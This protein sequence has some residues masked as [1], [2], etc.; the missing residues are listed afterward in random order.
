MLLAAGCQLARAS[1][2]ALGNRDNNS[3]QSARVTLALARE[4]TGLNYFALL[5]N[6]GEKPLFLVIGT[7]MAN[8]KWLCPDRIELL[9]AGP[10]GKARSSRSS[11][12]CNPSGGVAGRLDPL[13]IALAAGAT[14][15]LPVLELRGLSAGRYIVKAKYTG[16]SLSLR[17]LNLD[18][19]GLSLI[20]YWTGTVESNTLTADIR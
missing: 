14:Y 11:F 12:G 4:T 20:R 18:M 15:S 1:Q 6:E 8:D 9:I 13:T 10:D 2:T 5:R 3:G 7:I 19:Q 16:V 17:S